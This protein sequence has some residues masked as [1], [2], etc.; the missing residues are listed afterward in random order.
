MAL[1]FENGVGIEENCGETFGLNLDLLGESRVMIKA[2]CEVENR[3]ADSGTSSPRDLGEFGQLMDY[4]NCDSTWNVPRSTSETSSRTTS[5]SSEPQVPVRTRR[6]RT[7]YT[8]EQLFHLEKEFHYNK[9]LCRQRRIQLSQYLN[10]SERQIK[11]WFQNRRMKMKKEQHN[12]STFLQ[13]GL[14]QKSPAKSENADIVNRLM[15]HSALVQKN[16]I[17]V[18]EQPQEQ[19]AVQVNY[20]APDDSQQVRNEVV[21]QNY[22]PHLYNN[23]YY[24]SGY[25]NYNKDNEY[26]F[27][28]NVD[29]FA[30]DLYTPNNGG[31][32]PVFYNTHFVQNN[33]VDS[34]TTA[35]GLISL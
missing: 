35:E 8:T 10:L 12:K 7:A 30:N 26:Q 33:T 31:N 17:V 13:N 24:E 18:K 1:L 2:A 25:Y 22:P 5:E 29:G 9:Y 14:K 16:Q 27:P 21:Y 32:F 11:I 23:Q 28:N 34:N 6:I 4:N 3:E 20:N 15:N 19:N